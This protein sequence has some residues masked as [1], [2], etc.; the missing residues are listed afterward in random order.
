MMCCSAGGLGRGR[1]CTGRGVCSG[2]GESSMGKYGSFARRLALPGVAALV[3]GLVVV[4]VGQGASDRALACGGNVV[5][6]ATNNCSAATSLAGS[7]DGNLFNANNS[8]TGA[9]AVAIN[10]NA[11]SAQAAIRGT[12]T[13]T[14]AGIRGL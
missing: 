12:N 11:N 9:S 10:G 1:R 8:S 14:G 7:F 13:G 3:A 4:A 5:L 6:G 2:G